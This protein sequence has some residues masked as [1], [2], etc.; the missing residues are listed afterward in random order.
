LCAAV[1]ARKSGY[2]VEVLE[3]GQNPGG[4]A[5]SWPRG[6]YTFEACLHWL[7][8]SN[9]N[10]HMYSRWQEIF[11]IGQLKFVDPEEYARLETEHG[12]SLSIYTN[13][14]RMETELLQRAPQDAS[15]IRHLASAIRKLAKLPLPEPD[16]P[17]LSLLRSLPALPLLREFSRLSI[18]DY[19]RRFTHPLLRQFFEGQLAEL[20]A[21]ALVFSLAWMSNRNAGYAIGGSQAIIRLI[22][23]NLARLGGHLRLGAKVH[24]I[25]VER[26]RAVGVQLATGETIPADWVISAADG[27]STIYD[28]LGARY[29]DRIIDEMY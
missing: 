1:Y 21:I 11:D 27:H 17:V 9:P 14:D 20:S 18:Q 26:D 23:D 19:G 3:M 10:D 12:E 24:K 4:L 28:L 16:E 13:V 29:A 7:L 2:D 6:E 15:E 25:L 5:T 8:G 22:A